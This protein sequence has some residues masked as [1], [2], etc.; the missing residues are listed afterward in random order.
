MNNLGS[1]LENPQ[2]NHEPCRAAAEFFGDCLRTKAGLQ[3]HCQSTNLKLQPLYE[4]ARKT[5]SFTEDKIKKFEDRLTILL[6]RQIPFERIIKKFYKLPEIIEEAAMFD[7][8]ELH[9]EMLPN[10]IQMNINGASIMF[11]PCGENANIKFELV[12][13]SQKQEWI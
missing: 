9:R 6:I 2:F 11:L 8:F 7:G 13:D 5:N 1:Y 4:A 3:R 10:H 12:Y